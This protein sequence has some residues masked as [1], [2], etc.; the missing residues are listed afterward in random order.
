MRGKARKEKGERA[1]S[2]LHG[3]IMIREEWAEKSVQIKGFE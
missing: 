3:G 1:R 2:V